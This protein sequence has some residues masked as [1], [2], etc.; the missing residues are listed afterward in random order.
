MDCQLEN[1]VAEIRAQEPFLVW[2]PKFSD[3]PQ[4]L[5]KHQH[6]GIVA[7]APTVIYHCDRYADVTTEENR[8]STNAHVVETEASVSRLNTLGETSEET[9]KRHQSI[10]DSDK[11]QVQSNWWDIINISEK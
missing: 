6:L 10:Q 4:S 3:Q 1:G 7:P 5:S 2:V 9:V 11:E 8:I